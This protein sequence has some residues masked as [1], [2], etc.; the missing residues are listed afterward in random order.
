MTDSAGEPINIGVWGSAST[1]KTTY[2]A[3]LLGRSGPRLR[4]VPVG[5]PSV[6]HTDQVVWGAWSK[7]DDQPV[8]AT[9]GGDGMRLWDPRTGTALRARS[10]GHAHRPQ[11]SGYRDA[12]A[13]EDTAA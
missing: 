13:T 12:T 7:I 1:G 10:V 3:S 4:A 5:P 11:Q 9:G 6:G 2:L 8:L